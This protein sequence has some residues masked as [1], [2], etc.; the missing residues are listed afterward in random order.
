EVVKYVRLDHAREWRARNRGI[1]IATG[2]FIQF[3]DS[4]DLIAPAKLATQVAALQA[5]PDCGIS[6][7]YV[8]EYAMGDP[9]PQFPAR[10]TGETFT[11]LF[12]EILRGRIWPYPSPLFRRA[13]IDAAGGFLDRAAYP[14]WEL[15]CRMAANGVRLHHCRSFLAETRNTHR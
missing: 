3:L 11:T 12:P 1:E 9:Q 7:C 6:Y 15:E 5:N 10:R 13:V 2:E 8:R 4:D 14:D